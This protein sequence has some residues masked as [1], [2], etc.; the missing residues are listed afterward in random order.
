MFAIILSICMAPIN[1]QGQE[2][3]PEV[4]EESVIA[5]HKT[6]ALCMKN[7]DKQTKAIK[8]SILVPFDWRLSCEAL[9]PRKPI[10]NIIYVE[11]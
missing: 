3:G 4:C 7:M 1:P 2:I 10:K 5:E 11:E 9:Q 6:I 8:N